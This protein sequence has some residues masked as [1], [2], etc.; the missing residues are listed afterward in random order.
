MTAL[1]AALAELAE[2]AAQWAALAKWESCQQLARAVLADGWLS[3]AGLM[4]GTDFNPTRTLRGTPRPPKLEE[5]P[6]PL[7]RRRLPRQDD[8]DSSPPATL[9]S[10][11]HATRARDL[12]A[13]I[14]PMPRGRGVSRP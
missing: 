9:R 6:F 11:G 14:I 1:D 2:V 8:L 7:V 13:R 5:V 4:S 10:S 12:G 3:A